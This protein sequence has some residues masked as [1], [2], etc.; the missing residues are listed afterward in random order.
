MPSVIE[1]LVGILLTALVSMNVALLLGSRKYGERL[2]YVET[3]MD[4]YLDHVG[5]D[6]RKV[7]GAIK[8]H[9]EE[10]KK[11]NGPTVG[12]INTKELYKGG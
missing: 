7:N 11:S 10:L 3:K 2:M 6:V 8:T 1:I 4:I 9:L 5:L 12:C